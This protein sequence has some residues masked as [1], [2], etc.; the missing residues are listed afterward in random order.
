MKDQNQIESQALLTI[1]QLCQFRIKKAAI[2][3]DSKTVHT[4]NR[5]PPLPLYIGLPQQGQKNCL[6]YLESI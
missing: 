5:E 3:P 2:K 6:E 4:L 1:S